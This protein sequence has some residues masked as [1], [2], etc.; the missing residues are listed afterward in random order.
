MF[1]NTSQ[2]LAEK[3]LLVL[4]ILDKIQPPL[5]NSQITQF[6]LENDMMNYFMLQQFLSELKESGFI[7]EEEKQHTQ[8]IT[9]TEKGRSTLNYF[10]NRIPQ[11]Q[12]DEI[13]SLIHE[14]ENVFEEK[15]EIKADYIK[16][17]EEMYMVRLSILD[18]DLPII[19]L[20]MNVDS[21]Q[22]AKEM[23]DNWRANAVSIYH[24]MLNLL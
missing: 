13:N 23:C 12:K 16:L 1:V 20:K 22:R 6:V 18:N 10:I 11:S 17:S 21:S 7:L 2:Q 24:G 3:K 15:R 9:I 8:F 14:K 5:T 19:D 4:Y